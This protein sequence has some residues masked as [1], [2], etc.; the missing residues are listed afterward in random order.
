MSKKTANISA[1]SANIS[2]RGNQMSK[3]AQ[4]PFKRTNKK[5]AAATMATGLSQ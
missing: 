1:D 5:V 4:N 3:S 2:H